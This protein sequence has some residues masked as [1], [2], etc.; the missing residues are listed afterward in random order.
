MKQHI[1]KAALNFFAVLIV[2]EFVV[3]AMSYFPF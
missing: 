2:G 3:M 1:A